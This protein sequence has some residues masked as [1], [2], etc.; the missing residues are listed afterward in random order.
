MANP[1]I[2]KRLEDCE[3]ETSLDYVVRSCLEKRSWK[4]VS[5][6]SKLI[7]HVLKLGYC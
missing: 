6:K 2:R 4:F 7:K 3:I 1:N 5:V